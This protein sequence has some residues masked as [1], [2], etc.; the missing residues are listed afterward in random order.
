MATTYPTSIDTLVTLPKVTDLVSPV[1]AEDHNSLRDA[2]LAIQ[3]ELGEN[4]SGTFGTV[5]DR[6]NNV[7]DGY[8]VAWAKIDVSSGSASFG[9]QVGFDSVTT[10]SLDLTLTFTTARPDANYT[11]LVTIDDA[12]TGIVYDA[13][14]RSASDFVLT[15]YDTSF[16]NTNWSSFTGTVHVAV[17]DSR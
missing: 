3:S 14:N 9:D 1:V 11:I 10:S 4:P 13:N 5:L 12:T 16:S 7:G 15:Y 8:S 6:L 2:I 17:F